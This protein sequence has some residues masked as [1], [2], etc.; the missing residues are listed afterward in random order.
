MSEGIFPRLSCDNCGDATTELRLYQ[1]GG[2]TA[3]D[4]LCRACCA[5]HDPA[6]RF[7][8]LPLAQADASGL[9]RILPART[10]EAT[11]ARARAILRAESPTRADQIVAV[12]LLRHSPH[13]DDR[14]IATRWPLDGGTGRMRDITPPAPPAARQA[15]VTFA[16]D[17]VDALA[18][19]RPR[20]DSG[21]PQGPSRWQGMITAAGWALLLAVLIWAA[22]LLT[23]TT[24]AAITDRAATTLAT[25]F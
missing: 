23:Q 13:P 8:A 16:P 6:Q 5:A 9:T 24:R 15:E 21:T 3:D 2:W 12:E 14:Q 11:L 25:L 10:D 18:R 7:D 4:I 19:A 20:P 17:T 22:A 1:L